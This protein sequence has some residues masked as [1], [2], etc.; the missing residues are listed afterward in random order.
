MIPLWRIA[1]YAGNAAPVLLGLFMVYS[2]CFRRSWGKGKRHPVTWQ[3][4]AFAGGF[5]LFFVI[6]GGRLLAKM[7][8]LIR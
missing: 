7:A 2:A 1:I 4:R 5:G 6:A 3:M 8:G